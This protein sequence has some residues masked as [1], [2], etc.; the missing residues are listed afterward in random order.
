MEV[1]VEHLEE[2]FVTS[3]AIF[4]IRGVIFQDVAKAGL[5]FGDEGMRLLS[6]MV[7]SEMWDVLQS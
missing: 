2:C 6:T 5:E 4:A 3:H 7:V 1:S